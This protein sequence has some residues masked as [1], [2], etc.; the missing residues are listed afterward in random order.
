MKIREYKLELNGK[1]LK[2][3]SPSVNDA[4]DIIEYEL[5]VAEQTPFI[6]A[7]E[8]IMLIEKTEMK[9]KIRSSI[10]RES[11]YWCLCT[12]DDKIVGSFRG[13]IETH[14][15]EMHVGAFGISVDKDYWGNGIGTEFIRYFKEL[16]SKRGVTQICINM[17]EGN[18]RALAL[19]KK[20][21]FREIGVI[22]KS[23][24]YDDSSYRGKCILLCEEMGC[25]E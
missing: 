5:K 13:F 4:D 11:E 18:D 8:D 22:P 6:T 21:G 2:F 24:R 25:W 10:E 16:A 9:K 3:R 1:T 14:Y 7:P 17:V 15:R 12:I 23:Y 19:Y 20:M